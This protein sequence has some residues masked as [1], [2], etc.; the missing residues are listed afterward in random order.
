M[1]NRVTRTEKFCA[2][3]A[4][5]LRKEVGDVTVILLPH[6]IRPDDPLAQYGYFGAALYSRGKLIR[7]IVFKHLMNR[8]TIPSMVRLIAGAPEYLWCSEL[9][10]SNPVFLKGKSIRRSTCDA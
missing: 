9:S 2:R 8:V 10:N 7:S 3:V 6:R 5:E 4:A 1:G